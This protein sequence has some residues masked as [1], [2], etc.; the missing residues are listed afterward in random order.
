MHAAAPAALKLPG[1]R[2]R[3][4]NNAPSR[5][6]V[7]HTHISSMAASGRALNVLGRVAAPPFRATLACTAGRRR[8]RRPS[9][10][11]QHTWNTT[12]RRSAS[13]FRLRGLRPEAAPRQEQ[14]CGHQSGTTTAGSDVIA[15]VRRRICMLPR[16]SVEMRERANTRP[17]ARTR[18]RAD[19]AHSAGAG[20]EGPL[21]AGVAAGGSD[22][23]E[24]A[25][26]TGGALR[27]SWRGE[28]PRL[29]DD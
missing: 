22:A 6:S 27:C 3:G 29:R 4:G 1:L 10:C 13:T 14:N 16:V 19:G 20:G 5:T 12:R 26:R 28:V 23:G 2:R 21:A 17:H 9:M 24:G 8:C 15:A 7:R 11:P 18:T 25:G